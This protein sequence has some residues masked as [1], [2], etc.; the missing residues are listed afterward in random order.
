[1]A[2]TYNTTAIP[3][4]GT[5]HLGETSENRVYFNSTKVWGKNVQHT[6]SYV[7]QPD[8]NDSRRWFWC[9]IYYDGTLV[10]TKDMGNYDGDLRNQ[11]YSAGSYTVDWEI[12]TN[13]TISA[14]V[15]ISQSGDV[16]SIYVKG[17][18]DGTQLG[19]TY[20]GHYEGDKTNGTFNGGSATVTA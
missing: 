7:I 18:A 19:N 13:H 9:K 14:D 2:L 3:S 1:M 6:V 8:Q 12:A 20:V 15:I 5:V 16:R 4:S 17:Y 10:N 11:P